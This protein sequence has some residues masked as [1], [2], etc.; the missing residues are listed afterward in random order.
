MRD[1]EFSQVKEAKDGIRDGGKSVVG[2][3]Q[4]HLKRRK[5]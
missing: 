4:T 2:E 5:V 1:I 3:I